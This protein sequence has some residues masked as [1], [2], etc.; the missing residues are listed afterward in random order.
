MYNGRQ[1]V[2]EKW[3]KENREFSDFVSKSLRDSRGLCVPY[4]EECLRET[5]FDSGFVEDE[6]PFT[7]TEFLGYGG[8]K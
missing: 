1:K 7:F 2:I 4:T 6:L 3:C 8:V 5:F